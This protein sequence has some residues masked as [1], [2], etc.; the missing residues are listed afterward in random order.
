MF[1]V[2]H[3]IV[4]GGMQ[5]W[6]AATLVSAVANAGALGFITRSPADAGGL[7][8]EIAKPRADRQAVRREPHPPAVDQADALRRVSAAIIEAGIKIVE[9]AGHK[10]HEHLDDFHEPAS[11]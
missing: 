1:G 8:K 6:A 9:T 2:D 11:R 4:K 3:P 5:G 10:P 7:L